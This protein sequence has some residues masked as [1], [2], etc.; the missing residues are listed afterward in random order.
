[1]RPHFRFWLPRLSV[2][3]A[4]AFMYALVLCVFIPVAHAAS[5]FGG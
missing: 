4:A 5:P 3:T 2:G 1:M